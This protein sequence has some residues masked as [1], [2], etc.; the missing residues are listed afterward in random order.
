MGGV[1]LSYAIAIGYV[2]V[3]TGDKGVKAYSKAG[4]ELKGMDEI[5]PEVDADALATIL[6]GERA[7][8]TVVWQLLAS[9]AIPGQYCCTRPDYRAV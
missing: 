9:V 8:D 5:H 7:L 2:L 6:A 4:D 3:D 1:P